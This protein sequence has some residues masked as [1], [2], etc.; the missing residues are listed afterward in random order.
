MIIANQPTR[1]I[2]VG[3]TESIH[4]YLVEAT[5]NGSAVLLVSA[6][7]T[8]VMGI[9]NKLCVMYEGEIVAYFDEAGEVTEEELGL[10]M[11]GLKRQEPQELMVS[12]MGEAGQ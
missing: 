9:S 6:D 11:L 12:M 7:L 2:D 3:A 4:R 10:Y 5:E 1:G 8:E